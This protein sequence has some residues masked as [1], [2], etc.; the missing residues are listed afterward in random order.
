[1]SA[2]QE[3]RNVN[4]ERLAA[5]KAVDL[6]KLGEILSDDMIS[7]SPSGAVAGK[8]EALADLSSGDLRVQSS[9]T[10]DYKINVHGDTAVVVF[11]NARVHSYKGTTR[12]AQY[13][14]TCVYVK[15]K[16]GWKLVAQQ[17]NFLPQPP[18]PT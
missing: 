9:A 14:L 7:V 13:R 6:S 17:A 18:G 4:E 1:M 10:D 15:R 16:D 8:N 11:R 2:E 3:V 12:G 5:I